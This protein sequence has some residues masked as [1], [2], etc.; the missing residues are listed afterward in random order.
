MGGAVGRQLT[1]IPQAAPWMEVGAGGGHAPKP[2]ESNA[3]IG[4]RQ[5]AAQKAPEGDDRET[6]R[7]TDRQTKTDRHTDRQTDVQTD[8]HTHRQTDRQDRRTDR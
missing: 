3:G 7:Q 1:P 6:N 4:D 8:R 2:V 5:H